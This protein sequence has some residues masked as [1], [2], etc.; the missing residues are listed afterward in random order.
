MNLLHHSTSLFTGS[1][2]YK[3]DNI[4][5]DLPSANGMLALSSAVQVEIHVLYFYVENE[6]STMLS[7]LTC[8]DNMSMKKDKEVEFIR[9]LL[10]SVEKKI[11]ELLIEG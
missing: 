9:T 7:S 8:E 10:Q 5:R 1:S 6:L 11:K 2:D 4:P 3:S